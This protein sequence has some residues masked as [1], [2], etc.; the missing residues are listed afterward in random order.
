MFSSGKLALF[1]VDGLLLRFLDPRESRSS[2]WGRVGCAV[3]AR[4]SHRDVVLHEAGFVTPA[5]RESA[6]RAKRGMYL[7]QELKEQSLP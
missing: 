6:Q 2:P 1:L 4:G 3:K 7:W 5:P